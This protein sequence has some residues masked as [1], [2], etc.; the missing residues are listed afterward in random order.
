MAD[1]T[2]IFL[3]INFLFQVSKE[4]L[5]GVKCTEFRGVGKTKDRN[6]SRFIYSAHLLI[7]LF[8]EHL[9]QFPVKELSDCV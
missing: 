2:F 8:C 7:F 1:F 5:R 6:K 4:W 9:Q 3:I